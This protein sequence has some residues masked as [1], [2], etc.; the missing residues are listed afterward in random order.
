MYGGNGLLDVWSNPD[1]VFKKVDITKFKDVDE[2]IDNYKFYAVVH[3]AAIVGDPA[4]KQEP[5]LALR[6]NR[7]ASLYL[8]EKARR[9]N[10]QRFIFASTCSN[11]GRMQDPNG[12]V[13][14]TSP[15]SPISLYAKMKVDVEKVLLDKTIDGEDQFC[16]TSLR[17]ATIYGMS[18]RMR[19]DLTVNEFTKELALGRELSVFGEQ[20]WRPYC[21]VSDYARAVLTVL[22]APDDQVAYNVFNVGD[23]SQNYTKKMIVDELLR[24]LPDA[25]VKYIHQESDPRD[26]RVDF[27]RIR[28]LLG[29]RSSITVPAGIQEILSC[30]KAGI[31]DNPDHQKYYN[32]KIHSS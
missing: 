7:E 19:F 20:F 2:I 22:G 12:Y 10:I 15:L 29:F 25:K 31:I 23:T 8:L 3:L 1:F 11:Y 26:Y 24:Q 5:D 9:L 17:F 27:S 14:E 28:N 21:H 6:T 30:V 32:V 13:D 4:C 18:S 16:P